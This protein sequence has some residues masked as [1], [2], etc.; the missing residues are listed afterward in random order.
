VAL[1]KQA[2]AEQTVR[3]ALVLDLGDLRARAEELEQR[4]RERAGAILEEAKAERRKL[5]DGAAE[6][7]RAE[8]YA[9][10]HAQGLAKGLEEGR[11]KAIAQAAAEAK[12]LV[13]T[14]EGA[15]K[16]FEARRESLLEQARDQVLELSLEIARRVTKR[17]V[18]VDAAVVREQLAA[19]LRLTTKPSGLTVEVNPQDLALAQSVVPSLVRRLSAG[20]GHVEIQASAT[21]SRGS[22]II[23]CAGGEVDAS[24]ET[25]LARI[26]QAVR[27]PGE[28]AVERRSPAPM[29]QAAPAPAPEAQPPKAPGAKEEGGA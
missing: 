10:G 15:L 11:A 6:Q 16:D 12:A 4:T 29:A 25:Q 14:W 28:P 23:R 7:G 24:I 18:E 5:L 20:G 26:E 22:V 17:H 27:P 19:A 21:L 13:S 2:D 9:K 1:I 8:G 3:R